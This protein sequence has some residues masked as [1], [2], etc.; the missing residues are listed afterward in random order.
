MQQVVNGEPYPINMFVPIDLLNPILDAMLKTGHSPHPP[1]P[2]LGMST[3]DTQGTL[4]VARLAPGGPASR[5]GVRV[6]D[7]V[8]GVGGSAVQGGARSTGGCVRG[9]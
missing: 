3:Q 6:G 1:R 5:A 7:Q 4:V 9:V 8:L 2:W